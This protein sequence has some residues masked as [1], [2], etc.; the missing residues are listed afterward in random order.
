MIEVTG[1]SLSDPE[2]MMRLQLHDDHSGVC[3]RVNNNKRTT[4]G[5]LMI[6]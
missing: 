6:N 5:Q 4:S 1:Y 3:L 2:S